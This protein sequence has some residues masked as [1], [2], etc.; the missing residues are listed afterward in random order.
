MQK[1]RKVRQYPRLWA[2]FHVMFIYM[3]LIFTRFS[4][5]IGNIHAWT[6]NWRGSSQLGGAV[7]PTSSVFRNAGHTRLP[8]VDNDDSLTKTE[9][10]KAT[11]IA[12]EISPSAHRCTATPPGTGTNTKSG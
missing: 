6:R 9:P 1:W 11:H 10:S 5:L 3:C 8:M 7:C 4:Q 2:D 12:C